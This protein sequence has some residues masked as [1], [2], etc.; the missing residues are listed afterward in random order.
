MARINQE[1]RAGKGHRVI[2]IIDFCLQ[3]ALQVTVHGLCQAI[4][5]VILSH[6]KIRVQAADDLMRN[7]GVVNPFIQLVLIR[8]NLDGFIH[9]PG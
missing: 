2:L 4:K 5:H 9:I 3:V 1:G 8:K 6:V 7:P